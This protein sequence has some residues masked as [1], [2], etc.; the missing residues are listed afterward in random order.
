VLFVSVAVALCRLLFKNYKKHDVLNLMAILEAD[1]EILRRLGY[2]G[3]CS[4]LSRAYP[5]SFVAVDRIKEAHR[6]AVLQTRREM[7]TQDL[8]ETA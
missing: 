7:C 5:T 8:F 4:R 2:D 3:I 6:V 1:K